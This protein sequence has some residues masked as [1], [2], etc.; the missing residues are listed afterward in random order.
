[1]DPEM[2]KEALEGSNILPGLRN[3]SLFIDRKGDIVGEYWKRY[4]VASEVAQGVLPGGTCVVVES[5]IGRV[6]LAI[7]FDVNFTQ[8]HIIQVSYNLLTCHRYFDVV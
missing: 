6:G 1:M 8:V 3:A 7:G 2:E 4:P 5:D